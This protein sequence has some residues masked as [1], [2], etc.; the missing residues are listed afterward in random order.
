M[1]H[2]EAGVL[3]HILYLAAEAI[4]GIGGTGMGAFFGGLCSELLQLPSDYH[5]VY[6][7]AIGGTLADDRV[8]PDPPYAHLARIRSGEDKGIDPSSGAP[9]SMEQLMGMLVNMQGAENLQFDVLPDKEC[10]GGENA[11]EM[12]ASNIDLCKRM[13]VLRGFGAFLVWS[14]TAYF[15]AQ[16]GAE[17]RANLMDASGTVL[18]IRGQGSADID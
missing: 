17:C 4:P 8:K 7:F 15:R 5:S 14:G 16:A 11:F 9:F 6:H 3:G 10:F 13:C 12:P 18:Y 2:L 1:V